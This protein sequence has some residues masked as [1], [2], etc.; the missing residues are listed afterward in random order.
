[1][2]TTRRPNLF[3][4]GAMKAGTT[5][6]HMYLNMH[7][8]I[9]MSNRKEPAYFVDPVQLNKYWPEHYSRGLW[10]ERAYE[11]LF[12]DADG[13]RYLGESSVAYSLMPMFTGVACRIYDYM[14]D[15][16][17][18]YIVRHPF[19]RALSHYWW[20]VGGSR[21]A[22][23]MEEALCEDSIYL[24]ASDY[25]YQIEPYIS[26]FGAQR[27]KIIT[28]EALSA[29]PEECIRD[30][31]VWLGVS[32][33]FTPPNL[34]V[35]YNQSAEHIKAYPP[36]V[37]RSGV[38]SSRPVVAL[39]ASMP[40]RL[41]SVVKRLGRRPVHKYE[42]ERVDAFE[43]SLGPIVRRQIKDLSLL[44]KRSFPEWE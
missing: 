13:E 38:I 23:S 35:R 29:R 33:S 8:D 32:D 25:C 3:I 10:R 12:S 27:V 18:L 5:S 41:K 42:K 36:W 30:I 28:A 1:M 39:R 9:Y 17:V 20:E 7:P 4:I 37:V 2:D 14:P 24:R 31:F 21:E 16:R 26:R 11:R 40:K 6:L 19:R 43:T 34:R 44:M 22:R 15:S